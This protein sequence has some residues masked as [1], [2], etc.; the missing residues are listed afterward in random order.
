[1]IW[2]IILLNK[3]WFWGNHRKFTL[4]FLLYS[5]CFWQSVSFFCKLFLALYWF[6]LV[7][8]YWNWISIIICVSYSK[9][10][11]ILGCHIPLKHFFRTPHRSLSHKFWLY[12]TWRSIIVGVLEW[13]I[14]RGQWTLT[15]YLLIPISS[16]SASDFWISIE[17]LQRW[18]VLL[19]IL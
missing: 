5:V 10:M 1:M 3:V 12:Q 9:K 14:L 4:W 18:P 7:N 13:N 16:R 15:S 8:F 6:E 11:L 2:W 19:G 17:T